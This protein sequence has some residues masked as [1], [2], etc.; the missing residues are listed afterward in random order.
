VQYYDSIYNCPLE[1]FEKVQIEND[2][3]Y[4]LIPI[5]YKNEKDKE[6][7]LNS[8]NKED[9][10][11]SW[12]NIYDQ[13]SEKI[14]SKSNNNLFE[15]QKQLYKTAG[16]YR[17]IKACVFLIAQKLEVNLLNSLTPV[18]HEVLD[19]EEEV[20]QLNQF[21]YRIDINNIDTELLRVDKQ[22]RNYE[23]KLSVLNKKIDDDKKGSESWDISD[24]IF[25]ASKHQGF[26]F[27][28]NAKVI[29]LVTCLNNMMRESEINKVK[30][31][32]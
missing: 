9:A 30:K 26:P 4:L 12:L 32:G 24:T 14:K 1:V 8:F 20:K 5:D 22:S 16:E 25:I 28:D 10:E 11:K 27:K 29:K 17:V 31:D 21:G 23:T 18:E 19:Y 15:Y 2:Y 13:Y 7:H 3:K 6:N